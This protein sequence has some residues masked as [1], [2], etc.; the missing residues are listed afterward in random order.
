M[1]NNIN[2]Y[3]TRSQLIKNKDKIINEYE[4]QINDMKTE[5]QKMKSTINI[6]KSLNCELK[7]ELVKKESLITTLTKEHEENSNE[8]E[9]ICVENLKLKKVLAENEDLNID[10]Q[11]EIN[12]INEIN[13][14]L[15]EEHSDM[16]ILTNNM[17]TPLKNKLYEL[18]NENKI[19]HNKL[20]IP[21]NERCV[22][23]NKNEIKYKGNHKKNILKKL[24]KQNK[25]LKSLKK[26]NN[27]LNEKTKRK[28]K[29]KVNIANIENNIDKITVKEANKKENT[30]K[31]G[32]LYKNNKII[33]IG[34]K[35]IKNVRRELTNKL[36]TNYDISCHT[37]IDAPL[38]TIMNEATRIA[39]I[40]ECLTL[41][42]IIRDIKTYDLRKYFCFIEN[43]LCITKNNNINLIVNNIAYSN[44]NVN[45]YINECIYK[46]NSKINCLAMY[47]SNTF[48]IINISY[49]LINN[50]YSDEY[51]NIIS[52]NIISDCNKIMGK[53]ETINFQIGRSLSI[54]K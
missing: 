19:L 51:K 16:S 12:K 7:E 24:L 35:F 32:N 9:K 10:L 47:N 42:V 44:N 25:K 52:Y 50:V 14:T 38:E 3:L 46:I 26:N 34:D 39:K 2:T 40:E 27:K 20:T 33:L 5:L 11:G 43:L 41:A 15:T 31:K 37:Y 1:Q 21:L 53:I 6:Y 17:I 28:Y 8:Y 13:R 36:G 54:M 29:H 48:K 23:D 22:K 30:V 49:F 18:E 4:L 45:K